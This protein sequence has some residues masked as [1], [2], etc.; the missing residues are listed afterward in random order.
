[1]APVAY[2][3]GPWRCDATFPSGKVLPFRWQLSATLGGHFFTGAVVGRLEEGKPEVN[4][5][6]DAWGFDPLDR[7]FVRDFRDSEGSFGRVTSAGWAGQSL[8][9]AG[10]MTLADG[11]VEVREHVERLGPDLFTAR[12]ELKEPQGAWGLMTD[13]RC[14]RAP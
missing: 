5:S 2:F 8:D 9:F 13:E 7:L 10:T 3:L 11:R 14:Q 6:Q 1:M 12:W 4:V